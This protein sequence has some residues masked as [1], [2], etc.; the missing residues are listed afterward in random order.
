M[1]VE[2]PNEALV[3]ETCDPDGN[4]VVIPAALWFGK[5]LRD[6]AELAP[7]LATVLRA[8]GAPDHLITDP[9]YPGRRH[10]F[11]RDAG[12]SRWLRVVVSYEQEPA[13]LL[14]AYPNRKDPPLWNE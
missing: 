8:I 3:S 9:A 11:V 7:H 13:K 1:G 6:H 5:V 12:P 10:Y 4:R 14:T 2:A